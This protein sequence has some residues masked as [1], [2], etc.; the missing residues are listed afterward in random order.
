MMKAD[1]DVD[2]VSGEVATAHLSGDI[3]VAALDGMLDIAFT[4]NGNYAE[5]SNKPSIEGVIL[6]GNKTFDD[7][8]LSKIDPQIIWDLN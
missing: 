2:T 1:I 5:L 4:I 6:E 7:L 3:N 8:H